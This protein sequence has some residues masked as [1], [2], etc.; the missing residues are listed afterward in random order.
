[1][2]S[3]IIGAESSQRVKSINDG[4]DDLKP[5]RGGTGGRGGRYRYPGPV[6]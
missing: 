1:M 4:S 6:A 2:R 5:Y 3:P